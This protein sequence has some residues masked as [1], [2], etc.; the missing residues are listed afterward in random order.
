MH[1]QINPQYVPDSPARQRLPFDAHAVLHRKTASSAAVQLPVAGQYSDL[2]LSW[3]RSSLGGGANEASKMAAPKPREHHPRTHLQKL[4]RFP[5][6]PVGAAQVQRPEIS[7]E[8][9]VQLGS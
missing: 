3:I 9:L 5:A 2:S 8:R 4:V 1:T 6:E 7:E